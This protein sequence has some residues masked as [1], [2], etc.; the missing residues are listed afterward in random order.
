MK[1]IMYIVP[2]A[3]KYDCAFSRR[4][5]VVT[6]S[7]ATMGA[8]FEITAGY[9]LRAIVIHPDA[10]LRAEDWF[11]LQSCYPPAPGPVDWRVGEGDSIH[12]EDL[13]A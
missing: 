5:E 7:A 12:T 6:V 10:R 4:P 8:L 3:H 11:H 1:T 9:Q 2:S 13:F